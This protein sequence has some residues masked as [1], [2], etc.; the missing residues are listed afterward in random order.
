MKIRGL[1]FLIVCAGLA[2]AAGA[3]PQNIRPT[4]FINVGS[5]H[6]DHIAVQGD[7]ILANGIRVAE[8]PNGDFETFES[9]VVWRRAASGQWAQFQV[10]R[11]ENSTQHGIAHA[12]DLGDGIAAFIHENGGLRVFEFNGTSWVESPV[13]AAS[14][15]HA[16]VVISGDTI[17]TGE[18]GCSWNV[19]AYNKTANGHWAPSGT[20]P[21]G[22]RDC[23]APAG[24]RWFDFDGS[25]AA[26]W[27]GDDFPDALGPPF[28]NVQIYQR[29]GSSWI[30]AGTLESPT[31]EL[32]FGPAVALRGS[33]A[34]VNGIKRGSHLY[35]RD[36]ANWNHAGQLQALRGADDWH[37]ASGI[38]LGDGLAAEMDRHDDYDV[39]LVT[40]YQEK[41]DGSFEHAAVLLTPNFYNILSF[42]MSGRRVVTATAGIAVYDL[43]TTFTPARA[44]VQDDFE[45][46]GSNLWTTIPGSQFSIAATSRSRVYRQASVT[47]DA[48]AILSPDRADQSITADVRITEF[49]GADRWA[50]VFT[51]YTD[52]NNLYY[53]SLRETGR[54]SLRKKVAGV[55]TELYWTELPVNLNRNNRITLETVGDRHSIFV[56]GR[57]INRTI[58]KS[59][60]H[61]HA[62]V[63]TYRARADFDNVVLSAAPRITLAR[64]IRASAFEPVDGAW[65]VGSGN[66]SSTYTQQSTAGD[67][68]SL[69]G[70]ATTD[71][72]F[73]L[74]L[75]ADGF[76]APVAGKQ[77]WFGVMLRYVDPSNYYYVS[78]RSSNE[79]SLRKVVN[80]AVTVLATA[81][82]A[83][84]TGTSYDLR[85]EAIGA[86]LRVFR[87]NELVLQAADGSIP[88]GRP[89]FVTYR[90]A[91]RYTDYLVYMP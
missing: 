13:D 69:F 10:L 84:Q 15:N 76:A 73:D 40:V 34:A 26:V 20:L 5:L 16:Q 59:L 47:G 64:G 42:D 51:R 72:V 8:T 56:D 4:A 57:L 75:R 60:F 86:R 45:G 49:N 50:G 53:L 41:P 31:D 67:A 3:R 87:G 83:V 70:P 33:L 24:L 63:R 43:P 89:G 82:L 85:F 58:D 80:G 91:A 29:S 62:G 46:G 21:G 55:I 78:L 79:I 19:V 35:R 54:L 52:E 28:R 18:G 1:V 37:L 61:G 11:E 39:S 38:R 36:G 77:S 44:T 14:F 2:S 6:I 66:T 30:P 22:A 88:A 25:M 71:Q 48:A 7:W 81:P 17:L 90:T 23:D 74:S 9:A 27:N 68:R 12:A 65:S 32:V